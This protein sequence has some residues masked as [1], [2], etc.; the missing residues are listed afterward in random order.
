M[1]REGL[2][3]GFAGAL[4][5]DDAGE[6]SK[7]AESQHGR[8]FQYQYMGSGPGGAQGGAEASYTAADY[9]DVN[10]LRWQ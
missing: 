1:S 5:E 2:G 7:G 8:R 6:D 9:D 10:R 4:A 3:Y